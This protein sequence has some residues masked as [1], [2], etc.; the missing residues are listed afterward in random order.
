M[1]LDMRTEELPRGEVPKVHEAVALLGVQE[2]KSFLEVCEPLW[3][4]KPCIISLLGALG[5]IGERSTKVGL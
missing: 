3:R 1:M 5:E 4:C 2:V